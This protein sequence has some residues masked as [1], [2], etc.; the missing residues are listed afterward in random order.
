MKRLTG[1]PLHFYTYLILI[2]LIPFKALLSPAII[3]LA[4]SVF[5]LQPLKT[6]INNLK[7]RKG[8]LLFISTYLVYLIGLIYTENIPF[9]IRE[10]EYKLSLLIMPIIIGATTTFEKKSFNKLLFAFIIS[11][12][13]STIICLIFNLVEN[14]FSHIPIYTELSIFLNPAYLSIY[15]NFCVFLLLQK[16]ES[17]KSNR[18]L[19]L[20]LLLIIYFLIFNILLVSKMGIII[21]LGIIFY[22]SFKHLN[23]YSKLLPISVIV[24]S[25]LIGGIIINTNSKIKER[26]TNLKV[27]LLD[28]EIKNND[29]ESTMIRV[30]IWKEAIQIIKENPVFGVGTGDSK[31]SLMEKYKVDNI[32]FAYKNRFNAHNQYIEWYITLGIMGFII[33]GGSLLFTLIYALRQGNKLLTFFILLMSV[34]FLTESTLETQAGIVFFAFFNSFLFYQT[35]LKN[36]Y[37]S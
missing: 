31:D 27:A 18:T 25:L 9:G 15:T 21:M 7:V 26:F 33:L 30:L 1:L 24:A 29:T 37:N 11:C 5:L 14:S 3:L 4:A 19:A 13:L 28:K 10:I 16:C 6:T 34:S 23:K 12:F 32:P 20:K 22:Y 36:T 35:N 17:N 8:I 2:V